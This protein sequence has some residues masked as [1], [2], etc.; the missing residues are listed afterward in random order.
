LQHPDLPLTVKLGTADEQI[1]DEQ[2]YGEAVSLQEHPFASQWNHNTH[3]YPMLAACIPDSTD[4]VLD[5]GCGEGTFCRYVETGKRVVVGADLDSSVL[6]TSVGEMTSVVASA[7]ALPFED[8]SFA[9]V[10]MT[11]VLHHVHAEQ[12]IAEAGRVLTPG[13]VLLIL[14]FGRYGGLRDAP[15]ELRDV[16]THRVVSRRMRAWDPPSV[17]ADPRDTWADSRAMVRNALPG[18]TYRRLPMWRY[19]VKWRKPRAT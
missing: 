14:D 18:C 6:A 5:V 10:T 9:A 17:Q 11:M 7:E 1:M 8:E 13:G 3:Y 4:R 15:H 2:L 12:A 16:V 19:L